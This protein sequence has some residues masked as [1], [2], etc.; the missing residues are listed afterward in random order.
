MS[1][2][3]TDAAGVVSPQDWTAVQKEFQ[4]TAPFNYAVIDNFLQPVALA[5]L[6]EKLMN[7][8]G[9]QKRN[10]VTD[11][12]YNGLLELEEVPQIGEHLLQACRPLMSGLELT[13]RWA[14]MYPRNIPGNIHSDVAGLNLNLWITPDCYNRNPQRGGLIL[15]D[16][17]HDPEKLSWNALT[18][19]AAKEYVEAN[20]LNQRIVPYRCN[21]AI[22]FDAATFHKTDELDFTCD[23][24]KSFRINLTLAFN[25]PRASTSAVS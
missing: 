1:I 9:W 20:C 25:L 13:S 8:W 19:P 24:P 21:R 14:L 18:P 7:H 23:E 12:L 3:G 10:W 6:H 4:D 2:T 16:V 15:Y 22:L 11:H 5:G 17:K